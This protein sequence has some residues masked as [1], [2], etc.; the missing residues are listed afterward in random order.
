MSERYSCADRDERTIGL[1]IAASAIAAGDLVVLP[2]DTV[3]G[4]AADAFVPAAV[5]ALL[6]AKGRGHS[7]PPPVLV[8]SVATLDGIA[9]DIPDAGRAL[10]KEFWPGALTI[11]CRQQPSLV[12]NIGEAGETVAVRMPDEEISLALLE[13]TGPL[14]VSSANKSGTPAA[15]TC[16][17]AEEQLGDAVSIYLDGG[18][19]P[20]SV[21]S[22]IVD[23]T[24]GTPRI[25]RAG[26]ISLARLRAVVPEIEDL[27]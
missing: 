5:D 2:T 6:A 23:L 18:P 19:T 13:K 9:T 26:A 14:A 24:G 22:T 10:V 11:I 8:G 17:D 1:E 15:T 25:L 3:Y 16:D 12:W 20:G 7:M 21:A 4:I 27:G